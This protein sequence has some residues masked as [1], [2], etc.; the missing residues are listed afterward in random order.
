[1]NNVRQVCM[2]GILYL[3]YDGML[4]PLGQSQVLAYLKR[5]AVNRRIH[6]ISFEKAV[7]LANRSE[8]E[9]IS[10]DIAGAGIVWHPLRYHKRP[11]ALATLWDIACGIAVGFWLVKRHQLTIV[12]A[13]SYV[14]SVMALALKRLTGIKYLFDMRGFWADERVDGG[15]WPRGGR[16]YSVSKWF[17]RRFLLA[18]DHVISLTRAAVAEMQHFDYLQGQMPPFTVIPTCADLARFKPMPREC[19]GAGFVL[20]YVGS[21]GTW[22]LFDE[23]LACFLQL[24]K[25]RPDSRFL[26]VNRGEHP[27]ILERL[28]AAG[29]PNTAF[30]LTTATH[31]EVPRQM[32]RMDAGVFFIKPV[33]S[34][35]ASAP[36]KLAEFL[37]CGIPCL[38]NAGVGDMAEVL[39]GEQVGVTLRAFDQASLTA[40]LNKLLQLAHDPATRARCTA[41]AQKHFSLDEGAARYNDIYQKIGD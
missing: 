11:S 41:A 16:M 7:D 27:Y 38:G 25:L 12:H 31:S 30:E 24:L 26:I 17:E 23:V 22:Y 28:T 14:S 10:H 37:G 18:A 20:G 39:E 3:S 36:T 2:T 15:L 6:L 32:A 1:M 13:R 8:C 34:K 35:Q 33:F 40:G 29:V 4:E 21:A 9:R 19:D 5:L